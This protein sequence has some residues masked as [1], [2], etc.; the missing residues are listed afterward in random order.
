[1]ILR[2]KEGKAIMLKEN[3]P[4]IFGAIMLVIVLIAAIVFLISIFTKK[5]NTFTLTI[6]DLNGNVSETVVHENLLK[7]INIIVL[8][9]G[10][11]N[12]NFDTV[13]DVDLVHIEE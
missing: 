9:D 3:L 4:I 12:Y 11:V 13:R 1:M 8:P 5:D 7:A 6:T 10:S 2:L